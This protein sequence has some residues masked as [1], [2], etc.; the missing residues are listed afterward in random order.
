MIR[1]R[2]PNLHASRVRSPQFD[3]RHRPA[4][5]VSLAAHLP[6]SD[7]DISAKSCAATQFMLYFSKDGAFR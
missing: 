3:F 7:F 5:C 6:S 4:S 2:R 1:A